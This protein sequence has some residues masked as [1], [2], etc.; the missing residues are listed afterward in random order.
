MKPGKQIFYYLL[1]GFA[2]LLFFAYVLFP[3]DGL[4]PYFSEKLSEMDPNIGIRIEKIKPV[5]PP[6]MALHNVDIHYQ[7]LLLAKMPTLKIAPGL[8]T[9]FKAEKEISVNG[10]MG[11]GI[12]KGAG[13]LVDDNGYRVSSAHADLTNVKIEQIEL[14]SRVKE[15]RLSGLIDGN[16][17]MDGKKGPRGTL[18]ADFT[19]TQARVGMV[20]PFFGIDHITIDR[21]EAGLLVTSKR[22]RIQSCTLKGPQLDGKLSGYIDIKSPVEQSRLNLSGSA[23]PHPEFIAQLQGALPEGMLNSSSFSKRGLPFRIRGMLGNPEFL[24]R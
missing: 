5:V 11:G 19:V 12:I 18:T 20:N 22:V 17:K 1:F 4:K 2:A 23:R 3:S 9:L 13:F 8:T 10:N 21:A 14:L 6:G 24:L 16:I 15:Y 7:G